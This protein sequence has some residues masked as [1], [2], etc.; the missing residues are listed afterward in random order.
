MQSA[1]L[2]E[3][4]DL[5]ELDDRDLGNGASGA[6]PL[7]KT[8]KKEVRTN[9]RLEG[10]S[11]KASK[12]KKK[13]AGHN[14]VAQGSDASG[15]PALEKTNEAT[16][17]PL[18]G[19]PSMASTKRAGDN[20]AAQGSDASG[21]PNLEK[22][23]KVTSS[24]LEGR[25]SKASTK[26]RVGDDLAAEPTKRSNQGQKTHMDS[27]EGSLGLNLRAGKT[28]RVSS[29]SKNA[30]AK[31]CSSSTSIRNSNPKGITEAL[32]FNLLEQSFSVQPEPALLIS[33]TC[34]DNFENLMEEENL[35]RFEAEN[36]LDDAM[37]PTQMAPNWQSLSPKSP[38][39]RARV[40]PAMIPSNSW[41]SLQLSAKEG[42][43]I[44]AIEQM[45]NM[46]TMQ[47]IQDGLYRLPVDRPEDSSLPSSPA[48]FDSTNRTLPTQTQVLERL[49]SDGLLSKRVL[50]SLAPSKQSSLALVPDPPR[51]GA[52][53]IQACESISA[54]HC[55]D[56]PRQSAVESGG[57][58][59]NEYICFSPP[60]MAPTDKVLEQ[61]ETEPSGAELFQ[62]LIEMILR[63]DDCC[64]DVVMQHPT[65]EQGCTQA[66]T[67]SEPGAEYKRGHDT[68]QARSCPPTI[69]GGKS[70]SCFNLLQL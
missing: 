64:G 33:P 32:T 41:I 65:Q 23:N 49:V 11:S 69:T 1:E 18:E 66:E 6:P 48:G 57:H 70:S 16:N 26:K 45:S 17:S 29:K 68:N 43:A 15:A 46:Q 40:E 24:H 7:K 67:Q 62:D 44:G 59:N 54:N 27:S 38:V 25:P 56:P 58:I 30:A 4:S 36:L 47:L 8:R 13:R 52:D 14:W 53:F 10:R 35:I 28:A 51:T 55:L 5:S 61:M 42:S 31:T 21:A 3:S 34:I 9:S 63:K 37:Q 60:A 39:R 19:H 2:Q 20:L 50:R 12:T 22:P